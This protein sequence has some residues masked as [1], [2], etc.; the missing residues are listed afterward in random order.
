VAQHERQWERARVE[1]MSAQL[2][3]DFERPHRELPPG[4]SLSGMRRFRHSR[5]IG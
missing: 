1:G 5:T 2:R 3:R 4:R